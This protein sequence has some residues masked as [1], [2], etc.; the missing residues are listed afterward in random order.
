VIIK[1][2]LNSSVICVPFGIRRARIHPHR[3]QGLLSQGASRPQQGRSKS[4]LGRAPAWPVAWERE[5][6]KIEPAP[7]LISLSTAPPHS[8][9]T[10]SPARRTC[11]ENAQ[12]GACTSGIHT[13]T[14]AHSTPF[15]KAGALSSAAFVPTVVLPVPPLPL[16]MAS[17]ILRG[18]PSLLGRSQGTAVRA[19]SGSTLSGCVSRYSGFVLVSSASMRLRMLSNVRSKKPAWSFNTPSSSS[20]PGPA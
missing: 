1:A 7:P 20:R 16:A 11:S 13:R 9:Q 5:P 3:S 17:R 15:R 6:L 14:S 19:H 2:V 10:P 8:G 12:S 4:R 18:S